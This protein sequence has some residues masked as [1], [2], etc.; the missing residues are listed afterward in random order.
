MAVF[1]KYFERV[2]ALFHFEYFIKKIVCAT[3]AM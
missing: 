1:S 2:I 3:L